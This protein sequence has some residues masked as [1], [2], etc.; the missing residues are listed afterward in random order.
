ML[1]S[2]CDG[3]SLPRVVYNTIRRETFRTRRRE[4]IDTLVQRVKICR[5]NLLDI[6]SNSSLLRR[7]FNRAKVEKNEIPFNERG[8]G[9]KK[10][11]DVTES[12][13]PFDVL[14]ENLRYII[15]FRYEVE[16]FFNEKS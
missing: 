12:V 8:R 4:V 1:S 5:T 13:S 16:A 15:T 3:K 10:N 9:E 11:L 2:S 7:Q 14:N 6:V